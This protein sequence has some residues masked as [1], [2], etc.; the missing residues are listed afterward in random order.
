M[1]MRQGISQKALILYIISI[2]EA[3]TTR[4]FNT[5]NILKYIKSTLSKFSDIQISK[6]EDYC[7][8]WNVN[9]DMWLE[10][11]TAINSYSKSK[12]LE[13]INQ[14]REV[15]VEPLNTFKMACADATAEQICHAFFKLLDEINLAE[16]ISSTIKNSEN[17][18]MD[19]Q[20]QAIEIAREFKQLWR[21]L[22]SAIKSIYNNLREEKISLKE[23][24]ELLKQ[25]L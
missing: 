7:F 16:I 9:G 25:M 18:L 15:I 10:D 19:N 8:E 13:E 1:D 22:I 5:E 23:F 24:Y 17:I 3:V 6:I 14:I 21:I 12:E 11:F 4:K 20:T 2:F